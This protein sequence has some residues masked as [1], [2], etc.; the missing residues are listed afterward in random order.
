M[1][2]DSESFCK[3]PGLRS[4]PEREEWHGD[5]GCHFISWFPIVPGAFKVVKVL[6]VHFRSGEWGYRRCGSVITTIHRGLSRYSIVNIFFMVQDKAYAGVIWL[7]TPIYPCLPFKIVV[8]VWL[9]LWLLHN[10]F[11]I[12]VWYLSTESILTLYPLF[13]VVMVSTSILFDKELI[14]RSNC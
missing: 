7:S 13:P 2:T 4:F 10:N 14:V 11:Y 8:K 1:C 6:R 5:D 9:N 12:E 3:E